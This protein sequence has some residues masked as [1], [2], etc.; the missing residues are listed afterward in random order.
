ML[1]CGVHSALFCSIESVKILSQPPSPVRVFEGQPL[2]LEWTFSVQ[3][4]FR[5]VQLGFLGS[6]A[7]FVEASLSSIFIEAAFSDRLTLSTTKRNATVTFF[8]MNRT[9]SADYVFGV[10]DSSGVTTEPLKII[11]QCKYTVNLFFVFNTEISALQYIC[12]ISY[13]I[14]AILHYIITKTCKENMECS[15]VA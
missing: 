8:S 14:D 3:G 6:P 12:I 5:R 10:F 11:V 9:D 7:A 4:T 15:K 13:Y 1:F 2:R